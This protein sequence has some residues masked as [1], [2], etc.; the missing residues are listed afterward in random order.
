MEIV[1]KTSQGHGLELGLEWSVFMLGVSVLNDNDKEDII[2]RWFCQA[3][4]KS[5]YNYGSGNIKTVV[6][7]TGGRPKPRQESNALS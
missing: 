3:E 4:R 6:S 5:P 2:R 1:N 7:M